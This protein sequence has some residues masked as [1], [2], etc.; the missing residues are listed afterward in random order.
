M[1]VTEAQG[2]TVRP[3][4]RVPHRPVRGSLSARE[5]Q[6]LALLARGLT[7]REIAAAV[8]LSPETVKSYRRDDLHQAR[9]PQSGGSEPVR[10][11]V[12]RVRRLARYPRSP[13]PTRSSCLNDGLPAA[14]ARSSC[15]DG[16]SSPRRPHVGRRRHRDLQPSSRRAS[17]SVPP[18]SA[19]SRSSFAIRLDAAARSRATSLIFSQPGCRHRWIS[20]PF[21]MM[22]RSSCS[23]ELPIEPLAGPWTHR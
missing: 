15:P 2:I 7:N 19:T 17:S 4:S 6:V 22:A 12:R 9:S 21:M 18:S 23:P 20:S 13:D 5:S 1:A 16:R 14:R 10:L 11:L 3:G 8:F